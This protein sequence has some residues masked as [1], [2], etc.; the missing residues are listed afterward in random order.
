MTLVL[1]PFVAVISRLKYAQKF[2][3]LSVLF[4]IP[5]AT[6]LTIWLSELQKNVSQ[7]EDERVGVT[8][9][10]SLLP[11]MLHV[12]QHRGQANGYL[13]GNKASESGM[14]EAEQLIAADIEQIGKVSA[15]ASSVL[16]TSE[17]WSTIQAEWT[18]LQAST[19][20]LTARESFDQHSNLIERILDLVSL[21][22]DQSSLSLD[23]EVETF[24][25]MDIFVHRAP[26]LIELSAQV[27]G[28]GNGILSRKNASDE[29]MIEITVYKEQIQ[30]TLK[31]LGKSISKANDSNPALADTMEGVGQK[32]VETISQYLD[33]IDDTLL[34]SSSFTADPA[35]YFAEGTETIDGLT[36]VTAKVAAELSRLL[37]E[38]SQSITAS[39]NTMLIIVGAFILLVV[40]FYLAFYRNVR[41]TIQQLQTG[42]S[43]FAQGDL[44]ERLDLQTRDE[45][46]Y[47]GDAFNK[48]ADSLN[49][50]LR[51]N[52]EI[53]EQVAASSQELSAVSE[54]STK[55]MEQIADSVNSI[56]EGAEL[57]LRSFE[58]NSLAMN[59]MATV[60]MKIADAAS[61][62]SEAASE[63]SN[64]AQT[65][66]EK[67]QVS[68]SQMAR[69]YEAV[70]QTNELVT[71][72]SE[73]SNNI[74]SILDVIMNISSQTHILSLNANIEA[75]R[76]GEQGKGFMVV[77]KEV[78]HLA[79]QTTES[80]QS[81]SAIVQDIRQVVDEV[82]ASMQATSEVTEQGIHTNREVVTN[83]GNILSSV[84]LVAD[85]IQ[86]V[87]AAAEQASAST[88][89]VLAAY[90][91]MVQ[92]SKRAADETREMAAATE[93]Q[94]S[95]MEEVNSSSEVLSSS[96]QQLQ[97]ELSKFILR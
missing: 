19:K 53:S 16:N 54:E 96:A 34:K 37:E 73:H 88:D 64:G 21:A 32:S 39:R 66:G 41:S 83:L 44:S 5:L 2:I 27:R 14:I 77:A 11:L 13:N 24:Y 67:L 56:S 90:S 7:A 18:K 62:V 76:A 84:Q 12:Q 4:I 92:I 59:E 86:E 26:L 43:R 74:Q 35:A 6:L 1:K 55:V 65:G 75:A 94:L 50:L 78:G 52:Q 9:I 49:N 61:E 70:L 22:S 29:D 79:T 42:A 10:E 40:V 38:R 72:L 3:L 46:R 45:L 82:V 30:D 87:S 15:E 57:Q 97:D 51:R 69:I 60:I 23:P 33:T 68:N 8:Y 85:Q 80:A 17:A 48:M 28:Q 63:A 25:L 91:D 95:S 93:E 31:E 81:I 20:E 58:E 47:V 89:Q 71:K 36:T